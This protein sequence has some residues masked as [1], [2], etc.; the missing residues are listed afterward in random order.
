VIEFVARRC[1]VAELE[2]VGAFVIALYDDRDDPDLWL[3]IQKSLDVDEEDKELGMDWY[4]VCTGD[5]ATHYGGILS[6]TL[7]GDM[8]ELQLSE[9]AARALNFDHL[10]VHLDFPEVERIALRDGLERVFRD[11]PTRPER[12]ILE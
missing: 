11:G 12:V 7:K 1:T 6:C 9:A 5:A 8:L 3:E 2:D 4:Y 10:I